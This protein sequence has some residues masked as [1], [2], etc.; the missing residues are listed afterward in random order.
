ME[1]EGFGRPR[2]H[3]EHTVTDDYDLD[4]ELRDIPQKA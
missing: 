3:L 4:D 2:G 1:D